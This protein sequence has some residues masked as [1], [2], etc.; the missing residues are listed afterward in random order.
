M[1]SKKTK[2]DKLPT[3]RRLPMYLRILRDLAN[4]GGEFV[5]SSQLAD[6]LN[7]EPILVRKDLVL[8]GIVG[9]PRIGYHITDLIRSI[10]DFLGWREPLAT[11]LVGA[12]HLGT[13]I[14]G[15]KDIRNF[16]HKIVAAFDKDPGK[17]G[18]SI[19]GIQVF[20][21]TRVP[22]LMKELDV[23]LAILTVPPEEAQE[24]ADFL[25]KSGIR[26]I[27]NFSS[28]T[29]DVPK[30]IT[31]HKED[32]ISGLAVLSVKMARRI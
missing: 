5:S 31:T 8:T 32:L 4:K 25:V 15:Y 3:I 13:A 20:D 16:G 9:T 7:I 26:G 27:W 11:F 14:L 22:Q 2:V 17:V 6:V 12:G 29:L 10:E 18:T 24:A 28:I 21:I 1:Y 30:G 23:R 19:H